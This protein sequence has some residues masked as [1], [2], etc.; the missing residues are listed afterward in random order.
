MKINLPLNYQLR[1]YFSRLEKREGVASKVYGI[2]DKHILLW[3]FDD[4]KLS[5]IKKSLRFMQIWYKLPTIY[6]I[7]SSPNRYHAYCFASRTFRE[8][9]NIL[10]ATPEIDIKYL[11]LGMVRGYYTLRISSRKNDNIALVHKLTSS[12]KPEVNP[13]DI[14]ISE[15]MTINKGE[16]NA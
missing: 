15:Y 5:I 4:I 14:S 1:L 13:L 6:I 3:D 12:I 8:V 2:D 10:S 9:I 11:R 16:Q 7:S